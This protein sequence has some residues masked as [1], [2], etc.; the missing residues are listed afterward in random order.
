MRRVVVTG[1]GAVT[2]NGNSFTESWNS[3]LVFKSGISGI[4]R[5]D[6]NDL[7]VK[8]AGEI[9]GFDPFDH[10]MD[11]KF[12]KRTDIVSQY[13]LAS[14]NEALADAGI[15]EN[16]YEPVRSV[17]TISTGFGGIETY[18][19]NHEFLLKFGPKKVSPFLIPRFLTNMPGGWVSMQHNLQGYISSCAAACA[20]GS[21]SVIDGFRAIRDDLADIIVPGGVIR[22]DRS[23]MAF[24]HELTLGHFG[25]PHTGGRQAEVKRFADGR[26]MVI[27]ASI[28]GR[29][30]ALIT[31]SGW[32]SVDS[33]THTNRNAETDDSTVIYAR[34]KR[35]DKNPAMEL[36]IAVML[37]RTGDGLWS[38]E[39]LDPLKEIRIM[40]VTP[41]FSPLGAEI[42]LR[43]GTLYKVYFGEIDGNRRW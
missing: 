39:E 3:L 36:M 33:L 35:T 15:P 27:T 9:K 29:R 2:P 24:E 1:L 8:I 31:Y 5:F 19:K 40:D 30:V 17:C 13:V 37:H 7:A 14:A 16:Y 34:R 12:I 10:G 28:K 23:R 22:V 25:L 20:T 18:E 41:V 26:R 38:P 32:D 42:T 43:D 11:K 6:T 21:V 4:T